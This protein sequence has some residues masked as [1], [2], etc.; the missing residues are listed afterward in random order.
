MRRVIVFLKYPEPG[1]VKTRLAA[2][3]GPSVAA[4]L[5][6]HFA[7]ATLAAADSLGLPVDICY[8]P[9]GREADFRAWLGDGRVY[10][11]QAG[12]D[13]GRRMGAAFETAFAQGAQRVVLVGT[14]APDRPAHFLHEAFARLGDHDVVL[15]PALDGGYHCIAMQRD[16]FV[17]QAFAGIDWSTPR[18]LAQTLD[19]LRRSR[20]SVHMLPPWPDIDDAAG[21]A[22][23]L[24]THPEAAKLLEDTDDPNGSAPCQTKA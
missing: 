8:A 16:G 11:P 22:E 15:G 2:T 9:A 19:V 23:Y 20:R 21:L 7:Q 13:L 12:R 4:R 10:F 3:V 1:Q 6:R 14:D 18:V 5:A 17:P 24:K